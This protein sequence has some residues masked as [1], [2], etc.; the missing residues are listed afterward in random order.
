MNAF[1]ILIPVKMVIAF[2][3]V[4][5]LEKSLDFMFKSYAA[6]ILLKTPWTF[7]SL[8]KDFEDRRFDSFLDIENQVK[9]TSQPLNRYLL[10]WW[11]NS[12][13][14]RFTS[15]QNTRAG[16]HL[17]KPCLFL[18]GWATGQ[19]TR[20][21]SLLCAQCCACRVPWPLGKGTAGM[22]QRPVRECIG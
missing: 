21:L 3:R 4:G 22:G 15:L 7:C 9:L 14:F 13:C 18:W 1:W 19:K 20:R 5:W 11:L 8:K 2:A 6:K 17:P 10:V 16:Q 12:L